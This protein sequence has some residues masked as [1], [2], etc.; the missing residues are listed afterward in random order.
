L[1]KIAPTSNDTQQPK[2]PDPA[3]QNRN[4]KEDSAAQPA[5][6]QKNKAALQQLNFN[7]PGTLQKTCHQQQHLTK[8]K[9]KTGTKTA[10]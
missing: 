8:E 1:L 5:V 3:R 4:P 7:Q 10:T 6:N 9:Q 2:Q